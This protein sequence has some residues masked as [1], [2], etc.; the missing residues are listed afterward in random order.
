M[1][2]LHRG[3]PSVRGWSKYQITD[4]TRTLCGIQ[5]ALNPERRFKPSKGTSEPSEVT[6]QFCLS[7]MQ[8]ASYDDKHA[9][10]ARNAALVAS[11]RLPAALLPSQLDFDLHVEER[12]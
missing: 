7:L 3:A 9:R 11:L 12:V 8:P 6:C 1:V 2:H 4:Q 10:A 5:R